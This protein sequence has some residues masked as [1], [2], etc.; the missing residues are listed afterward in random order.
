MRGAESGR[1][2][3]ARC[4]RETHT[5]ADRRG[6]AAAPEQGT[7][8]RRLVGTPRACSHCLSPALLVPGPGKGAGSGVVTAPW[9][10]LR[11]R[12]LPTKTQNLQPRVTHTR[13]GMCV[14]LACARGRHVVFPAA[15]APIV[16]SSDTLQ[17]VR[18][19]VC[20]PLPCVWRANLP[21][22]PSLVSLMSGR[23]RLFPGQ[24]SDLARR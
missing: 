22:G 8:G 11:G 18:R 20:F 14:S 4:S 16:N 3:G 7:W 17:G 5:F 21:C 15:S 1:R 9:R 12:C 2:A 13:A 23:G 24:A 6:C 19:R 10:N